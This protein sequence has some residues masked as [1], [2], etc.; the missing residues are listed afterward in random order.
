[1]EVA[2]DVVVVEEVVEIGV[3]AELVDVVESNV[4]VDVVVEEVVETGVVTEL[5]DVVESDVELDVVVL[6]LVELLEEEVEVVELAL[7]DDVVLE[8]GRTLHWP[9]GEYRVES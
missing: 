9:C 1:M 4:E 5:V 2:D 8:H 7:L 6:T 3:V